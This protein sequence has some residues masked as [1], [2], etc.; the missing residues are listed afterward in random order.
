MGVLIIKLMYTIGFSSRAWACIQ[1]KIL[2]SS[3]MVVL[4]TAT[5][6]KVLCVLE[7]TLIAKIYR[8][9]ELVRARRKLYY[10]GGA[11]S[12]LLLGLRGCR[13]TPQCKGG[14]EGP[15]LVKICNKLCLFAVCRRRYP[16][17]CVQ[18]Q[19]GRALPGPVLQQPDSAGHGRL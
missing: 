3:D 1:S 8:G 19:A 11:G 13:V 14:S 15:P 4:V 9:Q 2:T 12:E 10:L 18:Q 16:V 6:G 7:I 17:L 5:V